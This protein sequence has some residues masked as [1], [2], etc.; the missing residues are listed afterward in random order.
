MV[1]ALKIFQFV[2]GVKLK[3]SC[4]AQLWKAARINFFFVYHV[5]NHQTAASLI[6]ALVAFGAIVLRIVAIAHG[7]QNVVFVNLAYRYFYPWQAVD[8]YTNIVS[9]LRGQIHRVFAVET[10]RRFQ[11]AKSHTGF[12]IF[13]KHTANF[14]AQT[15]GKQYGVTVVYIKT[16]T[17]DHKAIFGKLGAESHFWANTHQ[18]HQVTAV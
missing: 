10:N 13:F 9:A 2:V 4:A 15:L 11:A 6:A 14:A 5:A 3:Q 16:R 8:F 7:C 17:A 1:D 12:I 18:L